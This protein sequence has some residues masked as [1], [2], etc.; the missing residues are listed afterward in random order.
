MIKAFIR[1]QAGENQNL[2]KILGEG[3]SAHMVQ[4]T[5]MMQAPFS[6]EALDESGEI[7]GGLC[8][9][10]RNKRVYIIFLHV[11][12]KKRS[13]GI[14]TL[15]LKEL[16]RQAV[17]LGCEKIHVDSAE[18][19]APEFYRAHGYEQIGCIN[20]FFGGYDWLFFSKN[21]PDIMQ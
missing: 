6:L 19:Q 3:L 16:E 1:Y 2:E 7:L 9:Y 11:A 17:A 21:L 4:K 14:G 18:F 8:A 15:L 5:G 20:D 12:E 13:Q 10:E